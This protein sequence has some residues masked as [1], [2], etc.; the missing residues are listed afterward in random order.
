MHPL[1]T[2][3]THVVMFFDITATL[4]QSEMLVVMRHKE[5][6]LGCEELLTSS[7]EVPYPP[8]QC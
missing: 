4:Q 2:S 5:L 6:L 3:V 8:Q 7:L 1:I